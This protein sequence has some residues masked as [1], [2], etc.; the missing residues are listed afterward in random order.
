MSTHSGFLAPAEVNFA[1]SFCIAQ[2][3]L[4]RLD[5]GYED[6]ERRICIFLPESDVGGHYA[7]YRSTGS[8]HSGDDGAGRYFAKGRETG[9][10][11]D[12]VDDT[13]R[14]LLPENDPLAVLCIEVPKH[15]RGLT[16]R[17][18]LGAILGLGVKR[19]VI[20][21]IIV[22]EGGAD[23]VIL[24]EM[25]EFFERDLASVGRYEVSVSV[26]GR[27]VLSAA[28]QKT[29]RI[30]DTVASLRLDS[31]CAGAFRLARGKAQEAIRQGLVSIN[32]RQ[33]LK[34]DTEV[35]ENDRISLRGKGKAIL[36]EIG[37][38]TRKDRITVIIDRLK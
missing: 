34:P 27:E 3:A 36:S 23:V 13:A 7:G 37:S 5:G 9:N 20:G 2:K 19:S 38:R 18:Y 12:G 30:R 29:E 24:K 1:E 6:S 15:G 28:E 26:C 21:D 10:G 31:I 35:S 22:R 8:L 16:H 17:D 33:C 32:G 14:L 4:F 11:T 25:A